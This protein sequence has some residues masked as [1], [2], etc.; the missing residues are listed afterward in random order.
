MAGWHASYTSISHNELWKGCHLEQ[1]ESAQNLHAL[2][3]TI[4]SRQQTEPMQSAISGRRILR[5]LVLIPMISIGLLMAGV[6]LV[7]LRSD[8][9]SFRPRMEKIRQMVEVQKLATP[10]L[11]PFLIQCLHAGG[12]APDHFTARC[13][14]MRNGLSETAAWHWHFRTLF[15][16]WS[17]YWHF[18]AEE[19][20]LLY[21]A[22]LNDGAGQTGIHHLSMRL[23]GRPVEK[24]TEPEL[25]ALAV[26][27]RSPIIF[28][29]NR[30]RLDTLSGDLLRRVKAG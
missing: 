24:L 11:P 25:A 1:T 7:F 22:C 19:R 10:A 28:L 21:C 15:W 12:G 26:V 6:G 2:A 30:P 14:L 5:L 27:S 17:L 8:V 29:K 9:R 23:H 18:T 13:L 4:M 3:Q 16:S 20:G